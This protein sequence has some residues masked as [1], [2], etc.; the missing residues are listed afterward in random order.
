MIQVKD[1]FK[2][3]KDDLLCKCCQKQIETQQ[4][5]LSCEKLMDNSVVADLHRYEDLYLE[6][7]D[8]VEKIG[9][10]LAEKFNKFK[11]LNPSAH[12]AIT[13][14]DP[15]EDSDNVRAAGGADSSPVLLASRRNWN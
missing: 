12:N 5:L 9:H 3:G 2:N 7:A 13:S 10:I 6:D 15:P 8:K 11:K 4:H 1:N 14:E